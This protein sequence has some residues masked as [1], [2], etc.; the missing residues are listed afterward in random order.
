TRPPT[1]WLH[2]TGIE[3]VRRYLKVSQQLSRQLRDDCLVFDIPFVDTGADFWAGID[4]A[5]SILVEETRGL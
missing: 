2:R 1:D 5:E 4:E 3:N